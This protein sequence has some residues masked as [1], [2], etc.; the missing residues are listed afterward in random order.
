[1]PYTEEELNR[2]LAKGDKVR[3]KDPDLIA[4]MLAVMGFI[5][6]AMVKKLQ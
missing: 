2:I 4:K 6:T 5:V 1:M 3:G